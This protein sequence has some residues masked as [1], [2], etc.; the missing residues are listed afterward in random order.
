MIVG[1]TVVESAQL[2]DEVCS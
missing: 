1:W 2:I